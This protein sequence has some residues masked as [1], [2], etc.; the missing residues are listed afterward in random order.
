MIV[1]VLAVLAAMLVVMT[2]GWFVQRATHNGGWTDVFWTY[3]TGVTCALAALV[4]VPASDG[5]GWRRWLVAAMIA[6]WSLRL[7][8]YL[9]LRVAHG[10]EDTRYAMFR[11]QKGAGFQKWMFGLLIVQAPVTAALSIAVVLAA[12]RPETGLRLADAIGVA[13]L[14]LSV[15]GEGL[16]DAQMKRFKQ[17]KSA[18]GKICRQGLWAW[19]RHPNYFFEIVGWLPYA[20]MG[21]SL[22]HPWSLLGFAAPV[23]MFLVIRFASGIPPLEASMLERRGD[24]FRTYQREVSALI[25]WPP[26]TGS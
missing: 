2:V 24:A 4:P 3:G 6:V 8:T 9:A 18:H 7:G 15:G 26:K 23:V 12:H 22:A 19:S 25:P 16:A 1:L 5:A 21:V 13:I 11:K 10:P 17:D 20:V 14:V